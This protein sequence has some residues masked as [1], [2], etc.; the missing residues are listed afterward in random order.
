MI[1]A[2]S[3][4]LFPFASSPAA[5]HFGL[6][7]KPSVILIRWPVVIICT[8][9]LLYPSLDRVPVWI[10]YSAVLGYIAS[11]VALYF[12]PE[13]RFAC[14]SFYYPL[15]IADTIILTLSLV[16]N[17]YSQTDFYVTFFV[18]ILGSCMIEDA[19]M[20][21]VV[22]VAAPFFYS[23]SLFTSLDHFHPSVLL[24]LPFLFVV[25]LY[26]GYFTQF[27]RTENALRQEQ[28][29]RDRGR[30]EILNIVSHEFHTPLN[31]IAGY[32][33]AIKKKTWGEVTPGQDEALDKILQQS[34]NLMDI[35]SAIL[36]ITRIET[37]ELALQCEEFPLSD[38]LSEIKR[39]YVP[40]Q[41][42]VALQWV[43]P[44][45]L[46]K[47]NADRVKLTIILQNL[48]NNALKFTDKGDVSVTA[49]AVGLNQ[50]VEIEVKDT[51]IGIPKEAHALIFEKFQQ[52]DPS[53][54]RTHGGI[55][56]GLYM[57]K[58][59]TDLLGG[60]IDLES[61]PKKGSTFTLSLPAV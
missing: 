22:S 14:W 40:L 24:R 15:V 17:G 47:V 58:V 35:V 7:L 52:A 3:I 41:K 8:Y 37:G 45:G 1:T 44:D 6:A 51:G 30:K 13:D 5:E 54:T 4:G 60:R 55:G 50:R 57:A 10:S 16:V 32:V 11:N 61:E 29:L 38:Y 33:Q 23:V 9:L 49:R 31:V 42:S 26:Y 53:S 18:V 20:R 34:D 56:L 59:F 48:I 46:P 2:K 27:I 28:E 36:D 39:K 19:K 21:V 43:I 25:S 12:L